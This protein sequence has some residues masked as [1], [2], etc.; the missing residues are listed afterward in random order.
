MCT[1]VVLHQVSDTGEAGVGVLPGQ[2]ARVLGQNL[3]EQ[4][5]DQGEVHHGHLDQSA[6]RPHALE[7]TVKGRT[8]TVTFTYKI[9]FN[10]SLSTLTTEGAGKRRL[11]MQETITIWEF[12]YTCISFS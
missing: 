4:A 11:Y 1:L 5:H 9:R 12:F 2:S 7:H 3:T 6:G 8:R 10:Y